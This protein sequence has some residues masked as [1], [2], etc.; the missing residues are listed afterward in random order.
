MLG[1]TLTKNSWAW[2]ACG[3]H[4]LA[5]DFF[6]AGPK[7]S[8]IQAVADWIKNGYQRLT[9]PGWTGK[10]FFSWRFW[11]RGQKKGFLS[12]GVIRDSSDSI[13]RPFPLMIMG[14]G[15][16]KGWEE[17]WDLVPL[18]CEETWAH[19]EYMAARRFDGFDQFEKDLKLI[20]PPSPRWSDIRPETQASPSCNLT[21]LS[22]ITAALINDMSVTITMGNASST[23]LNQQAGAWHLL[24]KENIKYAPSSVFMGGGSSSGSY[25]A[26]FSRALVAKDFMGLWSG[27]SIQNKSS[28]SVPGA[29]GGH[30]LQ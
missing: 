25:M 13:G 22:R 10:D 6:Y 19:M 26:V 14:S 2:G 15:P 8:F 9:Q 11:A 5:R 30:E 20:K 27:A 23:D 16:L 4:P 29:I 24:L 1:L 21:D 3:K 7:D 12:C 17:Q 28:E 18:V